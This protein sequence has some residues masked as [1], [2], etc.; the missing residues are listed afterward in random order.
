MT[1]S[2]KTIHLFFLVLIICAASVFASG[3]SVQV[4]APA[5]ASTPAIGTPGAGKV[6]TPEELGKFDGK[7]GRKAYVAVDGIVYDVSANKHW[8]LGIHGE[9]RKGAAAGK[10][11]TEMLKVSPPSMRKL[12][13]LQPVVGAS[14]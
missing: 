9:C 4:T 13:K 11:L 5:T 14:R 1:G 3:C 2:P 10:D 12:I 7:E 6:F 8:G